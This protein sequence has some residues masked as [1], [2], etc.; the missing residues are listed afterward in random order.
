[1]QNIFN[2]YHTMKSTSTTRSA[3]KLLLTGLLLTGA[4]ASLDAGALSPDA[5]TLYELRPATK[6]D[7]ALDNNG[8]YRNSDHIYVNAASAGSESQAWYLIPVEGQPGVY[9]ISNPASD[10]AI[11]TEGARN[12]VNAVIQWPTEPANVNQC[13][14]L[15]ENADGSV[16]FTSVQNGYQLGFTDA[17]QNGGVV[18]EVPAVE[19][20]PLVNWVLTPSDAKIEAFA[21]KTSSKN[22]WENQHILGIN[23]LP[24]HTTFNRYSSVEAMKADDAYDRPWLHTTSDRHLL[25][26]G[27]WKFSWVRCPEERPVDFYRNNYDDSSWATIPVPSNWEMYGYGTPIYTNIT[28]PFRNNPPYI[29]GKRGYTLIDEP[30]AVGSYRRSFDIPKDWKDKEVFIT[31]NGVSSAFYLWINGKKVGYSQGT[32]NDAHFD[33]TKYVHTGKNNIAVEVYRWCDGSYLEDQ[34]MFR[35]SGIQRDVYLTAAPKTMLADLHLESEI[36]PDYGSAKLL[37]KGFVKNH[38]GRKEDVKLH[39]ELIDPQGAVVGN[40]AAGG[41][42]VKGKTDALLT[43][44]CTVGHPELW[45]AEVPN[46]YTVNV[47]LTDADGKL[48]E[49]TTQKFGFRKVEIKDKRVYVNGKQVFF[50]GTDHHDIHPAYGHAVPLETMIEDMLMFK[51]NNINTI[52]TSHYPKDPRMNALFDY[53]GIYVM[54]EADQECHGNNSLTQNPEWTDAF[55]DRA[56]RMVQRD[57]NHPSIVFWSLGNESGGGINAVAERDAV[58]QLDNTRPIHYCGMNSC[59]DIDSQMYPSI[60]GMTRVDRED[61]DKPYFL[62]EYAHAMGNAMGNFAEYWDYIENHSE[63]MIGGC[64]W[65]WVDQSLYRP[66]QPHDKMYFGGSFGDVPNDND[67]CCNGVVTGDRR[68]TPKLQEVKNVYQYVGFS[69]KGENTVSLLNKYTTLNLD[70]FS[71]VYRLTHDGKPVKSGMVAIPSCAPGSSVDVTVPAT[72]DSDRGEW[73]LYVGAVLNKATPWADKGY[74]VAERQFAVKG[75]PAPLPAVDASAL[76]GYA[77]LKAHVEN[78]RYLRLRNNTAE[79]SFDLRDGRLTGIDAGGMQIFHRMSGPEFNWYR[80]IN[81]TTREYSETHLSVKDINWKVAPDGKSATINTA[82]QA[83]VGRE[84][85]VDYT[86]N[87]TVY[88]DGEVDVR[89]SFTTPDRFNLPRLGLSALINPAFGHVSWYG[90]GPIENYVDRH[91][92]AFVGLYECSVDDMAEHYVRAQ[93]MGERTGVRRLSLTDPAGKGVEIIADGTLDFSALHYSDRDLWNVK[94]GHDLPDI[95]RAETVLTLDCVHTGLGNG[96]CGPQ[97][98]AKYTIKPDTTYSY[99]FRIKPLR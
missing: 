45:D 7:I 30:N 93:S 60:E 87:Y 74:T 78:G 97:A 8:S 61:T 38:S 79:V 37:V 58:R 31:F 18:Y 2:T 19:G 90:R 11:D 54:D 28:Y 21:V 77:P 35:L 84:K 29:Q 27:D 96:S 46:L 67:F 91:D 88:A 52:R 5:K 25:L 9:C 26:N 3:V 50:K 51:R 42:V 64:I 20:N 49:A 59:A 4:S 89:A 71:L 99:A 13:W 70:N 44:D 16:T 62:C 82:M 12:R 85:P 24:G 14:K 6:P 53:Y 66:G 95:R 86:V 1:M 69:L 81:N 48:L 65:D 57:R 80:S 83:R 47:S 34:D 56:V 22:D 72:P 73:H 36:A 39:V 68:I 32:N 33:I 63:R 41:T 23:K 94:Y 98:M 75:Q 43:A 76:A 17:V 92:A 10:M 15:T 40:F 55:V